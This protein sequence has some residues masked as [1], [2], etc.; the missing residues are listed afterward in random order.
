MLKKTPFML[1]LPGLTLSEEDHQRLKTIRPQGIILF[2]RNYESTPQI[3][4]LI[5]DVKS[6]LGKDTLVS[7]DH[8][9]G[10]VV[11]FPQALPELPAP[12]ILGES[13]DPEKVRSYSRRAAEALLD[14]GINLNLAPV[15]DI[16]RPDSHPRMIDRCFGT[17]GTLVS[18]M[19][20][21]FIEGMQEAGVQCTAKHFPGIG[22]ARE[23]T[24]DT[25]T[26]VDLSREELEEI[27]QPFRAT[28]KAGVDWVMV[29]HATY[30]SLDPKSPA[31]FSSTIIQDILRKDLG[32]Q[33]SI[34]SDD[35]EMGAI[36]N[37][38][39]VGKAAIMCLEAGC[40]IASLCLDTK[41]QDEAYEA[42]TKH[43]T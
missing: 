41:L 23:D 31:T 33:G 34:I 43:N 38:Y 3:K 24:H 5:Q 10:R 16:L 32:F 4:K 2:A 12:R 40:S 13:R 37:T 22:P 7:V 39:S 21:A 1:G 29:T 19:A 28:I 8:E 17:E 25:G 11:R 14:W 26:I 20:I 35:L 9:G 42:F 15:V 27:W 18:E 30:P 36:A 6:I